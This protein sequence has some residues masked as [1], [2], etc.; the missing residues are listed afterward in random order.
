[1]IQKAFFS[2]NGMTAV[3]MFAFAYNKNNSQM[4]AFSPAAMMRH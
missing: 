2:R 4:A 1:M 3:Y